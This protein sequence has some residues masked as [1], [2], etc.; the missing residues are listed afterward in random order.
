MGKG[1][2]LDGPCGDRGTPGALT[3]GGY[4]GDAGECGIGRGQRGIPGHRGDDVSGELGFFL[5]GEF[6]EGWFYF[7]HMCIGIGVLVSVSWRG[8]SGAHFPQVIGLNRNMDS[9]RAGM[10]SDR[11]NL[12]PDSLHPGPDSSNP[13]EDRGDPGADGE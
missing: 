10:D 6:G 1:G 3:G 5:N 12:R 13:G 7:G 9:F 4:G 8:E 2:W 11:G